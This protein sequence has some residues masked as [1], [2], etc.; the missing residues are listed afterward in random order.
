MVSTKRIRET[1]GKLRT[2]DWFIHHGV[3]VV[4]SVDIGGR[5]VGAG[6]VGH[7]L[8]QTGQRRAVE[9]LQVATC[10]HQEVLL[11][12]QQ[13][14]L[15]RMMAKNDAHQAT[16]GALGCAREDEW[17]ASS[18]TISGGEEVQKRYSLEW[19]VPHTYRSRWPSSTSA[20]PAATAGAYP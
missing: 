14:A 16:F 12:D 18:V 2:G 9:L 5:G 8:G 4:E 6:L 20:P 10:E 3:V 19:T 17:R 7:E 13:L 15:H 1:K 11:R